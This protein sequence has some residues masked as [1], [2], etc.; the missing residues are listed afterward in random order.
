MAESLLSAPVRLY[1]SYNESTRVLWSPVRLANTAPPLSHYIAQTANL[2]S[3]KCYREPPCDVALL[4]HMH[5]R[6][7]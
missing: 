2:I 7:K 5:V 4:H 1:H 3:E 6:S